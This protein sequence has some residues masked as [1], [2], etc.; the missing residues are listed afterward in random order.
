MGPGHLNS[1][2]QACMVDILLPEPLTQPLESIIVMNEKPHN[3]LYI[4]F[5]FAIF[6]YVY[7]GVQ[8]R[9]CVHACV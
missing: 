4:F 9:V 2:P 8:E 6:I 1:S 7:V 3:V 5:S